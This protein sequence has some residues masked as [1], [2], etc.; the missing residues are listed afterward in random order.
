LRGGYCYDPVK[1]KAV[2][3][4]IYILQ[5]FIL[6]FTLDLLFFYYIDDDNEETHDT[7]VT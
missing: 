5:N 3:F 7:T 6:D 2:I 4:F 1:S